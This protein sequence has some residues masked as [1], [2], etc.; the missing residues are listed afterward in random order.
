M[1]A[2]LR[3]YRAIRQAWKQGYPG[4]PRSQM[5][6]H[7]TALAAF[8][9]GMVG[10][11]SSQLLSITTHIP[12]RATPESRVK[13]W[14]RWVDNK[15]MLE[16]V[17]FLPYADILLS[18]L[19]LETVGLGM[20]GSGVGR[21]CTAL[22]IHVIDKGRALPLAWRVRQGAKGHFPEALPIALIALMAGVIPEGTQV[23][24]LGD[25]E[26][27]GSKLQ[28]TVEDAGWS[29]VCRTSDDATAASEGERFRLDAM[30][31]CIKAG[32][33][34]ALSEVLF[35]EVNAVI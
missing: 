35:I 3:R 7:L 8:I 27:D 25:G 19:A 2:T 1:S 24:F 29:Y 10:S 34:V 11:K 17:S 31:S 12:E 14:S 30:G 21:H 9:S 22:M 13:R 16:E 20:D 33:V 5:A 26:C 32:T 15:G 18:H 28:G 6:R 23:V 4:E